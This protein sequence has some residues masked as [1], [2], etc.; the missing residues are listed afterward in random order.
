MFGLIS[1]RI[2]KKGELYLFF[3]KITNILTISEKMSPENLIHFLRQ[4][5]EICEKTINKEEGAIARIEGHCILAAWPAE[6]DKE[7]RDYCHIAF[8]LISQLTQSLKLAF[9]NSYP[10]MAVSISICKGE[11]IYELKGKEYTHI[12]G[13]PVSRVEQISK[14]YMSENNIV[15]IDESIKQICPQYIS[16]KV[17]EGIYIV[18]KN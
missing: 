15:L 14:E 6:N 17:S 11:C 8:L 10:S 9:K 12:F 16:E 18:R 2:A 7:N 3:I 1:K 4:Y 13:T 5:V